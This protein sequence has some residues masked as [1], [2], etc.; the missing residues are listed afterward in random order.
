MSLQSDASQRVLLAAHRGVAGAN[1]P[2]NSIPAFQGAL[3]QG[4]DLIELDI[5]RSSDGVLYVFHPGMEPVFLHS[6]KLISELTS[7]EVDKLYLVNQDHTPTVWTAPRL[8]EILQLLKGRCYINLDK[9]W[10][11]PADITALVRKLGMQDQ[12]LIKTSEDPESISRV[13]EVAPDLLYMVIMKNEDKLTEALL[14]RKLRY[15]GVEAL[16]QNEADPICQPEYIQ[17]MRKRNLVMW[18]NAIVYNYKAV[19]AAG[20][21]DDIS[22]AESEEQGWGWLARRGFNIIQ[23]D[24]T[25]AAD[26]FLHSI[27]YR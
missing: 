5:S 11:C 25:M 10:T 1:I 16:F 18:A 26:H 15:V 20:H 2:C 6:E 14:K 19:L 27:G 8:E 3:R 17:T 9:F 23:T 7:A 12:V 22:I 24:W 13:E 21:T 4:A